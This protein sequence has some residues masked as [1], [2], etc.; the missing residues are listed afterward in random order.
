MWRVDADF[1][2]AASWRPRSGGATGLIGRLSLPAIGL[3]ALGSC[4]AG[5]RIVPTGSKK[6]R[7]AKPQT[8]HRLYEKRRPC[9]SKRGRPRTSILPGQHLLGAGGEM[10]RLG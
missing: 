7:S 8:L 2:T 4:V 1:R 3:R 9:S 10:I 5:V 6:W